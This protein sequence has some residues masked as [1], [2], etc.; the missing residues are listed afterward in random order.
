MMDCPVEGETIWSISGG[1]D[2]ETWRAFMDCPSVSRRMETLK[3]E[4]MEKAPLAGESKKFAAR[5]TLGK[6][7]RKKA[8]KIISRRRPFI[9]RTVFIN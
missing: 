6:K 4:P 5:V 1:K 3:V 2:K 9:P 8:E 7:K